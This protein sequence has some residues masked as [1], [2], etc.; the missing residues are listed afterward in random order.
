[1]EKR[2]FTIKD[3]VILFCC[4]LIMATTMGIVNVVLSIFYPVVSADLEVSRTSFALTGTI[5]AVSGMAASLFWGFFY[6]KKPL[7]I[8]MIIS[9]IGIGLSFLGMK[10][11]ENL[12]HFYAF[13]LLI[14]IFFG[15]I[16]IIPVSIII[17]RHFTTKTGLALS[18]ALAGSGVGP[19]VLNPIINTIINNTD[20]RDGYGLI[21]IVIF[22]ITLPCAILVTQMTKAELQSKQTPGTLTVPGENRR[23]KVYPWFWAFLFGTSLAGLTGAG[24]LANLPNYMNDL[25]FSVSRISFVT[26]AYAASLVIGKFILGL[27]YDRLGAKN[28]T[29]V[30]GLLMS[31]SLVLMMFIDKTPLLIL[32][33][34][35]IGIGLAIGTVSITWLTNLF[36]GKEHYSKYYGTVQFANSLGIAVGVPAISAALENLGNSNL[37]W[38]ALTVLSLVMVVLFMV[39]IR[40][41]RKLKAYQ[42]MHE[43]VSE[44]NSL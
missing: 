20:W 2:A 1:M 22:A 30:S 12:Y 26:S 35:F 29:L 40:G 18:L 39:S 37:L 11:A 41:N 13:A 7:Q 10:A 44:P 9:I 4:V 31:L 5:T 24:V 33:L 6:S 14:G 38:I 32:M 27:L 36:F 23:T 42:L 43:T 17:T 34:I 19:M 3:I 28:A 8:P 16:S 25:N 21:A 15:G